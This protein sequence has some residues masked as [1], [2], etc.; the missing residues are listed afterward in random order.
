MSAL[1]HAVRR[2]REIIW[3]RQVICLCCGRPTR[4]DHLCRACAGSLDALR[5]TGPVCEI[6]GHPLEDGQ[7]VFCDMTGVATL[8]SVWFYQDECRALV[9]LLKYGGVADAAQPMADG[10]ADLARTLN[11]PP[12]TV[13]TWPTMP[14]HRRRTRGIDHGELLARAV[15]DRLGFP[16]RQLMARSEDI[17]AEP[18]ASKNRAERL[19]RLQG[20]FSC[21]EQLRHPVLL[22][23]DVLTTSATATTC[24]ECLLDAGAPS[25]TVITATQA[26]GHHQTNEKEGLRDVVEEAAGR[27][28]VNPDDRERRVG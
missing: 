4:G 23:D 7:C 22:I 11:L 24:S 9:R 18:Q 16:A 21:P 17:A 12:E 6:C 8:R 13:I 28:P 26:R 1:R 15:S 25:V 10:M 20:A 2:L 5:V 27:V 19:T 14:I 3:P